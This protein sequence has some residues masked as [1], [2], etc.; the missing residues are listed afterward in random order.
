M[1]NKKPRY[2]LNV[3]EALNEIESLRINSHDFNTAAVGSSVLD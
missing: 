2:N 3:Y 1:E